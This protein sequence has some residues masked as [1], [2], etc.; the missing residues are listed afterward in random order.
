MPGSVVTSP[1]HIAN[2]AASPGAATVYDRRM[3]A[4]PR[5]RQRLRRIGRDAIKIDLPNV[6]QLEDYTCGVAA[7][8][9]VCAY[10]GVGPDAEWELE[11]RMGID[12]EG[13]DPAHIVR[14]A[15]G[16]GLAVREYRPMSNEQLLA[17]VAA[18]RP[19]LVMLQAWREPRPRS[20]RRIWDDGHW[21]VAIG[22]DGAGVYF[23]DPSLHSA[24][25][26]IGYRELDERW[27]DIEGRDRHQVE[28]YGVAIWKKG[29]GR[30]MY[31]RR[32]RLIE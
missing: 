23:E 24:R 28:R 12:A 3:G 1:E 25:G 2:V 30:S 17:C 4:R 15:R 19:V 9:S 13:T 14:A 22:Y 21:V 32:A 29:G 11:A 31:Q 18:R 6:M 26:F 5:V 10:F 8:L 20:Y 27:H 7:L 16:L